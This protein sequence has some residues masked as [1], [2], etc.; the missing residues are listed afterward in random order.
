MVGNFTTS[1][2]QEFHSTTYNY[3]I[4]AIFLGW[5]VGNGMVLCV[6]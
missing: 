6:N 4:Q 2:N 1:F 3:L 5:N